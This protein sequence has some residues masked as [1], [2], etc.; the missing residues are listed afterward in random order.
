LQTFFKLF[1]RPE[2]S[3]STNNKASPGSNPATARLRYPSLGSE[4][5]SISRIAK[6]TPCCSNIV[7]N[8]FA[9]KAS[10]VAMMSCLVI[11]LIVSHVLKGRHFCR[12]WTMLRDMFTLLVSPHRLCHADC[13]LAP[14]L[15]HLSRCLLPLLLVEPE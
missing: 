9:R 11:S 1:Y 10:A 14:T 3:P 2:N 15:L 5:L 6:S 4:M 12:P 8:P 7:I 13:L